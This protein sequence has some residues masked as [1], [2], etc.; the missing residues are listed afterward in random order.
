MGLLGGQFARAAAPIQDVA[1]QPGG[2]LVGQIVDGQAVPQA[3]VRLAVVSD[4]EPV[5]LAATDA[6]GRFEVRGLKAGVFGIQT[7]QTGVVYRFWAPNTAPPAAAEQALLVNDETVVRGQLH[8]GG[9][10]ANH[11]SWLANPWVLAAIVAA[12]IAIPLAVDDDAS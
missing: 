2:R 12:A 11:F 4:G 5:A 10:W 3:G 6:E 1:L 9:G 7:A 8:G